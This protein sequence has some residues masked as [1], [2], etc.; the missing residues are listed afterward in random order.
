MGSAPSQDFGLGVHMVRSTL[1]EG[2]RVETANSG[3]G[4]HL[5]GVG[6]MNTDYCSGLGVGVARWLGI[7]G[8]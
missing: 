4:I 3:S 7:R 2:T 6:G 1:I 8:T 5:K